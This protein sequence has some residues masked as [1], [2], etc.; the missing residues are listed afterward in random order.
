MQVTPIDANLKFEQALKKLEAIVD[1]MNSGTEELDELMVLYEQ[2]IQYMKL[3]KQKLKEAEMQVQVLTDRMN[4]EL[5]E[6]EKN[7]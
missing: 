2:G 3:C 1:K 4:K 7:G 5:Q 6:E